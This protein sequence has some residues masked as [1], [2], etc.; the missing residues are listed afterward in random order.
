MSNRHKY[1]A[2]D[3]DLEM[4]AYFTVGESLP[5]DT[6]AEVYN[7]LIGQDV[8]WQQST[9]LFDKNGKEIFDGDIIKHD[10]ISYHGGINVIVR[11]SEG[12]FYCGYGNHI[13]LKVILEKE[14]EIIGNIYENSDL[15]NN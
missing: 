12:G 14:A 11:W 15:I 8:E 3:K 7:K 9:G 2:W 4:F 13:P 1:R 10:T 6:E 5:T